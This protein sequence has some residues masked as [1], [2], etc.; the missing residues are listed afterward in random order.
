MWTSTS[1]RELWHAAR[2]AARDGRKRFV[3]LLGVLF[4]LPV[5]WGAAAISRLLGGRE[6]FGEALLRPWDYILDPI[7]DAYWADDDLRLVA[8]LLWHVVTQALLWAYFGGRLHRLAIVD[9]AAGIKED[10]SAADRFA[11]RHWRSFAGAR[12][13][14]WAG[15]MAPLLAL[16]AAAWLGRLPGLWGGIGLVVAIVGGVA[17]AYTAVRIGCVGVMGGF[18]TGPALASEASDLFDAVTRAR[19]YVRADMP[20]LLGRRLLFGAGV[21]LGTLWRA[22]LLG[23]VLFL[24]YAI[25]T[26]VCP[27]RMNRLDALWAAGGTPPDA[28]RLGV[29]WTDRLGAWAGL[30][31]VAGFA[32]LWLADLVS[33]VAC[34]RSA[35]YLLTR[36][37]VDGDPLSDLRASPQPLAATTAE[38]AGFVEVQRPGSDP[39]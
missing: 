22:L 37:S 32:L 39:A 26:R 15:A 34:A 4:S 29:T 16:V 2:R 28:A 10:A 14:W 21:L 25:L 18:L 11:R 8:I 12:L 7:G 38:E 17:L 31:L 13:A 1:T 20:A 19:R 6:V 23:A 24:L 35:V 3:A 33:R 36:R 5:A 30:G 27:E 9:L